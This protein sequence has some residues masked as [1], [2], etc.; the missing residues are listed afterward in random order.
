[1]FPVFS[2]LLLCGEPYGWKFSMLQG[3]KRS[4][5]LC[6]WK[7]MMAVKSNIFQIVLYLENGNADLKGSVPACFCLALFFLNGTHWHAHHISFLIGSLQDVSSLLASWPWPVPAGWRR[8]HTNLFTWF[9]LCCSKILGEK[10]ITRGVL[11]STMAHRWL[12]IISEHCLGSNG[13]FHLFAGWVWRGTVFF[14][15]MSSCYL[16]SLPVARDFL[17]LKSFM[18]ASTHV[19]HSHSAACSQCRASC[20]VHTQVEGTG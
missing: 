19:K 12:W 11:R 7:I 15:F 6:S 10:L 20:R 1:M 3:K 8:T 13:S 17:S 18:H 2:F 5:V 9:T 16:F 14:P 4:K